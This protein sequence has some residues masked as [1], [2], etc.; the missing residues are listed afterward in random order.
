MHI[1]NLGCYDLSTDLGFMHSWD[2]TITFH[3]SQE[4]NLCFHI[5]TK[6]AKP[7]YIVM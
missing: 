5:E 3:G 4:I 7:K 6:A 1:Y 2:E